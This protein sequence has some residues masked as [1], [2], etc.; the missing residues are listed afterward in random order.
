MKNKAVSKEELSDAQQK[1]IDEF[2][3]NFGTTSGIC[4]VILDS[5]LYRLGSNYAAVFPDQIRRC[6]AEAIKEAAN[7]WIFP[8][9]EVLLIRGPVEILKSALEPLGPYQQLTAP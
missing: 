8:S 5:E 9:G 7:N 3:R 6:D 1:V 4:D 2:N